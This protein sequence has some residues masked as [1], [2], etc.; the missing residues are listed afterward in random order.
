VCTSEDGPAGGARICDPN[1]ALSL[2]HGRFTKNAKLAKTAK[3]GYMLRIATPLSEQE[4]G[5]VSGTIGCGI[6]VHRILGPGF[7]ER[8]YERAFC[9]ELDSRGLSFECQRKIDVKYKQWKIPGQRIDLIVANVVIVEIKSVP[10]LKL[11]H[12]RQLVSYLR[13]TG[14]KVGLLMNFNSV[15]L[16][17]GLQRVARSD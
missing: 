13:T 1:E 7:S 9:L 2:G 12:R 10:K 15:T 17:S 14:L 5:I 16:K 6:E 8:I 4:E 3:E 11:L